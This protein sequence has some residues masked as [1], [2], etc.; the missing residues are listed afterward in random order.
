MDPY[1]YWDKFV[2]EFI[3]AMKVIEDGKGEPKPFVGPSP[4]F[5]LAP[6]SQEDPD[7]HV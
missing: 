2:K 5:I 3:T 6:Q 1:A 7:Q 4:G